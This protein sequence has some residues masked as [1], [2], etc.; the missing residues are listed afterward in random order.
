MSSVLDYQQ[1]PQCKLEQADFE[2]NCRTF[3]E[4]LQCRRCGYSEVVIREGNSEGKVTYR[5]EINEG[6]GVLFYRWKDAIGFLS[7]YLLTADDVTKAEAWL[8]EKLVAG[9]VFG[10]LTVVWWDGKVG[11]DTAATCKAGTSRGWKRDSAC[12]RRLRLLPREISK[13]LPT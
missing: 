2:Y 8:R 4:Y 13:P 10:G 11:D 3:E 6:A 5:H 9:D 12:W 7:Y 1:C